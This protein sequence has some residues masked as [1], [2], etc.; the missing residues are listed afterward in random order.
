MYTT[1]GHSLVVWRLL[2]RKS[3]CRAGGAQAP[4]RKTAGGEKNA[5]YAYMTEYMPENQVETKRV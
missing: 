5:I 3:A 1:P 2:R 4:R